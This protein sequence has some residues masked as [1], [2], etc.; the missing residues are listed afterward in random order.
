MTSTVLTNTDYNQEIPRTTIKE[1]KKL[2]AVISTKR[3]A[4]FDLINGK[5]IKELPPKAVRMLTIIF[6]AILRTQYF[7]TNWKIA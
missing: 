4:G 1:V 7:P 2:F 5:I 3:T 6:N